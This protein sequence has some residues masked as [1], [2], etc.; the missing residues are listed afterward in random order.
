MAIRLES[1]LQSAA[2]GFQSGSGRDGSWTEVPLR[3]TEV[4]SP[5]RAL[6]ALLLVASLLACGAESVDQQRWEGMSHDARLLYVKAL[7]G[8]EKAKEAKGGNDRVYPLAAEEYLNR[9]EAAY[10]G[11]DRRAPRE[12]FAEMSAPR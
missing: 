9:I 6:A 10:A 5:L 3:R 7:L 1:G 2:A 8:E 4:R 12:I 11:G